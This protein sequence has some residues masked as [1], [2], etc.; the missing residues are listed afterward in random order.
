MADLDWVP[1]FQ[2]MTVAVA[3]FYA[4]THAVIADIMRDSHNICNNFL[5]L[6]KPKLELSF[7]QFY[8]GIIWHRLARHSSPL[9]PL[10]HS[11]LAK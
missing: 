2:G 9:P 3:V 11:R 7:N 1:C 10:P 6:N 5:H 4:G 8:Q